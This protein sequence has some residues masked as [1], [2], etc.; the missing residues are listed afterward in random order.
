MTEEAKRIVLLGRSSSG[1]TSV[2]NNLRDRGYQVGH[3]VPTI[4]LDSRQTRK[5]D[6]AE[7]DKRQKLMYAIQ[8]TLED[9]YEGLIFQDRCLMDN[10]AYTEILCGGIPD[11][12]EDLSKLSKRYDSV[13]ELEGLPFKKTSTRIESG[14]EEAQKIYLQVKDFYMNQ[15]FNPTLVPVFHEKTLEESITKRADF[16]LSKL[17]DLANE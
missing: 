17:E 3:E 9:S 16:I 4:I 5:T 10:Y 1:K 2:I 8:K 7:W 14:E 15:G 12:F 11:Y 6:E 13:F